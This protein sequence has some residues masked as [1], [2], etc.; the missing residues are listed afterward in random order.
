MASGNSVPFLNSQYYRTGC[1]LPI[2]LKEIIKGNYSIG[3][4]YF[5]KYGCSTTF[6]SFSDWQFYMENERKLKL[7]PLN[8]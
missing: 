5:F 6:T 7:L 1:G 3:L 2:E 4:N 8:L